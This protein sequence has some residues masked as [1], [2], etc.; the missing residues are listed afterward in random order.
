MPVGTHFFFE[1]NYPCPVSLKMECVRNQ[2]FCVATWFRDVLSWPP[3]HL[4]RN[5]LKTS[6][7]FPTFVAEKMNRNS[8]SEHVVQESIDTKQKL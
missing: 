4:L 2:L 3:N 7:T 6:T 5:A 1:K 8:E